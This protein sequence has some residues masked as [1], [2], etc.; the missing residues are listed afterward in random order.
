M[1]KNL[2]FGEAKMIADECGVSTTTFQKAIK[3][4]INTPI[5]KLILEH[6]SVVIQQR[7]IRILALKQKLKEIKTNK[8]DKR[9]ND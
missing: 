7:E 8:Y 2:K 3:G 5:A 4:E 9:T 6:T 1:Q